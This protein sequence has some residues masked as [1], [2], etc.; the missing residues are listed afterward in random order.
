MN[1]ATLDLSLLECVALTEEIRGA[2]NSVWDA[3]QR[4]GEL[5]VKAFNGDAWSKMGYTT[6][7]DY[8]DTEFGSNRVRLPMTER[9]FLV[10]YLRE[11]AHMSTRAIGSALNVDP[12]TAHRDLGSNV[13]TVANSTVAQTTRGLDGKV[14]RAPAKAVCVK[15]RSTVPMSKIT[16]AGPYEGMCESCHIESV[17]VPTVVVN[18]GQ[19]DVDESPCMAPVQIRREFA[20][21]MEEFAQLWKSVVPEAGTNDERLLMIQTANEMAAMVGTL[22]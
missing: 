14:R 9:R 4:A 13:A 18:L 8:C 12:M 19:G 21:R 2:M 6:W 15:C 10:Q 22:R 20:E 11:H 5:I 16:D 3:V 17:P 7:A 1:T